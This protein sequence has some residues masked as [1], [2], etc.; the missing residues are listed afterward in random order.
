MV[1]L[2]AIA[3]A[4]GVTIEEL[5]EENPVPENSDN[6]PSQV[7]HRTMEKFNLILTLSRE[8]RHMIYTMIEA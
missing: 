5:I 2:Y 1:N 6:I 4:L 7:D 8:K 3:K